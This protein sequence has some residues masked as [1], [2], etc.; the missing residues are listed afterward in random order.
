MLPITNLPPCTEPIDKFES[1]SP[2]QQ[3]H[4]K[5]YTTGLVAASNKTRYVGLGV[6]FL[7][8]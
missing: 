3:H 2:E 7:P 6:V 1:L 8:R 4:A 5:T